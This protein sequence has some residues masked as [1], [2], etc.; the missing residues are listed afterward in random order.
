MPTA[1]CP[2][3]KTPGDSHRAQ[4]PCWEP[5][6]GSRAGDAGLPIIPYSQEAESF[7][8]GGRYT[9]NIPKILNGGPTVNLFSFFFFSFIVMLYYKQKQN[10]KT[11][12]NTKSTV[13]P[14]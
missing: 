5:E 7:G 14:G 9:H 13:Y 3:A 12:P 6:E 2:V 1:G 11:E 10:S 8:D 4:L